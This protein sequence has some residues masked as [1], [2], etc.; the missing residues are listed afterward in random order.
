MARYIIKRLLWLV[1]IM[2]AVSILIFTIMYFVPGDSALIVL[3]PES[4]V[5]ERNEW[6]EIWGLND[7]Y[8][9][10]LFRYLYQTFFQ[11]D[12]GTSYVNNVPIISE[13][14]SRVPR[15]FLLGVICLCVNVIIGLPLGISCALHQNSWVDHLITVLAMI[16]VSLPGFWLA[17]LM[18]Q[19]FS[20]KI[21]LLP[22]LGISSWKC[23]IM[24]VIA[25]SVSGIAANCRQTRSA[26]LET[27]RSD[28]ITTARAKGLARSR[29]IYQHMLP[30]ALIPILNL[31]GGQFGRVIA[32]TVVIET[33]FSF[34]GVGTYL[35]AGITNR[36]YPVVRGS[37]LILAAFSAVAVLLVDITYG[38]IDPRIKAQYISF[39]ARKR[40]EKS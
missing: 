34:P 7:P 36:D 35:L 28:F 14:A 33:V 38:L 4:T 31:L 2:A 17:M 19:L 22:P 13:F 5:A 26:V 29:V 39:A 25:G 32:G 15:T 24:P 37:V 9:K 27:I 8:L 11:F 10:Q 6:R 1:V 3:G 12:L 23:W 20:V 30:N 16:G 18:I 40:G 21:G